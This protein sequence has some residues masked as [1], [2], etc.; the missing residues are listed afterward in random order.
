MKLYPSSTSHVQEGHLALVE[1]LAKSLS[2]IKHYRERE[3]GGD[4]SDLELTFSC[5][6]KTFLGQIVTHELV[7]GG[8]TIQVTN[9][10]QKLISG[11]SD[12]LDIEDLRRHTHYHGGYHNNHKV[13]SWLWDIVANDLNMEEKGLFLSLSQAVPNSLL[14]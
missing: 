12:S 8:K 10:K 6:R 11:D 7:P 9:E 14:S 4:V 1:N 13:I 2:Y 3:E 5:D